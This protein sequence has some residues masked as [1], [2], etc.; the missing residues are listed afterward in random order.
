MFFSELS[1]VF[2]LLL[3]LLQMTSSVII[4]TACLLI[5]YKA[6]HLSRVAQVEG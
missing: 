3:L 4:H 5:D 2:I 6:I 1:D